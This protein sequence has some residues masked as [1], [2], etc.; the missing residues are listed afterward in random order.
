MSANITISDD[1]IEVNG[2]E[3]AERF[4]ARRNLFDS[5]TVWWAGENG[6]GA[7]DGDVT[8]S[9][10]MDLVD[11]AGTMQPHLRPVFTVAADGTVEPT[12]H[13]YVGRTSINGEF[14]PYGDPVPVGKMNEGLWKAMN[15]DASRPTLSN[16]FEV[17]TP[18]DIVEKFDELAVTDGGKPANVESMGFLGDNGE[19]GFFFSV[20][21]PDWDKEV[22]EQ[23]ETAVKE[24]FFVVAN[25]AANIF[26]GNGSTIVVCQNTA[27]LAIQNAARRYRIEHRPGAMKRLIEGMTGIYNRA[28]AA[29]IEAQ[30]S[31][32]A[33]N[34]QQVTVDQIRWIAEQAYPL[35]K[36]VD[37]ELIG[38][39]PLE[40]R[41]ARIDTRKNFATACIDF[42]VDA[43]QNADLYD[44][45]GI[46]PAMRG[47]ALAAY[48]AITFQTSYNPVGRNSWDS[49]AEIRLRQHI[50]PTGS[51]RGVS[52]RGFAA[53]ISLTDYAPAIEMA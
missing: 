47:T 22:A 13:A 14:T 31:F 17:V 28:I 1:K 53:A 40:I 2:V 15:K 25:P 20:P 12:K 48:Q 32:I 42:V 21:M 16:R 9:Q 7:L 29:R 3:V 27:H 5:G 36:G 23:L 37:T 39:T 33:L 43:T 18:R 19:D 45:V 41:Q 30:N 8:A 38:V 49:M 44:I 46:T 50:M 24:H 11:P 26:T 52:E 34:N 35:P 6:N 4:V 51:L 10:A